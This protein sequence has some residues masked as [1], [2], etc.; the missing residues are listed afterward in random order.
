MRSSPADTVRIGPI[1]P[2]GADERRWVV[3]IRIAEVVQ[4]DARQRA[5]AQRPGGRE[6]VGWRSGVDD[7]A[8]HQRDDPVHEPRIGRADEQGALSAA[9]HADHDEPPR[10]D[11]GLRAQALERSL[12]VLQWDVLQRARQ[13][14]LLE[15]G[16][17]Q[18]GISVRGQ[19]P[20][21]GR[22]R[23]A[24]VGAADDQRGGPAARAGRVE[25][26]AVEPAAHP[27]A[28]HAPRDRAPDDRRVRDGAPALDEVEADDHPRGRH[29]VMEGVVTHAPQRRRGVPAQAA[30]GVV[31]VHRSPWASVVRAST[32]APCP[33]P[34]TAM[35]G[36]TSIRP[37]RGV[38]VMVGCVDEP[39]QAT[40]SRATERTRPLRTWA[41]IP[42]PARL[43]RAARPSA[44]ASPSTR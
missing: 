22:G 38:T 41:G 34:V 11:V 14:R 36:A 12:E 40:H 44:A 29:D 16:D 6:L 7:V 1:D 9:R 42:C 39:P 4:R 3:R 33:A 43:T 31:D 8:R 30:I 32:T 17:R 13:P 35:R 24:A 2:L 37:S 21:D 27:L 20:C 26:L 10:V 28:A 5:A 25:P 19:Q 23:Q 15:V 18:S